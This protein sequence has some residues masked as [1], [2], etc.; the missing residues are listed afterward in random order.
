MNFNQKYFMIL[1]LILLSQ[2]GTQGSLIIAVAN[3]ATVVVDDDVYDG[4]D[5]DDGELIKT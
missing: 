3:A 1:S 5:D 2:K 4:D